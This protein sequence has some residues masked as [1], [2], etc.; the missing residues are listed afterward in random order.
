MHQAIYAELQRVARARRTTTYSEIAPLA[1]LD[2]ASPLDRDEIARILYEISTNE[3]REGRPL[4]SAVVVL[5]GPQMPGAGFFTMAEE[6]GLYE[7]GDPTE[8]FCEEL[9]RVHDAWQP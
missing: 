3:H 9:R 8:F 5:K 4:L 1:D 2:M 6:L 7:R